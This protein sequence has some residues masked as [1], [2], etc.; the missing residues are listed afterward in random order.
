MLPIPGYRRRMNELAH[1]TLDDLEA[2]KFFEML[3]EAKRPADL[4]R[5]RRD[6]RQCRRVA[7]PISRRPSVSRS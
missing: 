4:C 7:W 5:R 3:G 2:A 1:R 6:Q